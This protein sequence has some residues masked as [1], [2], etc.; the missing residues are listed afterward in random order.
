MLTSLSAPPV[1]LPFSSGGVADMDQIEPSVVFVLICA[2]LVFM[3]IQGVALFYSGLVPYNNSLTQN[4]YSMCVLAL[5]NVQF[6]FVGWSLIHRPNENKIFG[7]LVG[8]LG[9]MLFLDMPDGSDVRALVLYLSK[10]LLT[11]SFSAVSASV[12]IGGLAGRGKFVPSLLFVPVWLTFVYDPIAYW[13]WNPHGWSYR[14]G[15]ID[16]A[17]GTA[18]HCTAGVTALVYAWFLGPRSEEARQHLSSSYSVVVFGTFLLWVGWFG[19]NCGSA[20]EPSVR[21]VN[22]LL[23]TQISGSVG[24]LTWMLLDYSFDGTWS[25]IGFCSGVVAG[26]VCVT[27]GAAMV[28]CWSSVI[29]GICGSLACNFGTKIKFQLGVDDALDVFAAHGIGGFTGSILTG[30]FAQGGMWGGNPGAIKGNWIQLVYQ[31]ISASAIVAYTSG[32]SMLILT[33]F[34]MLGIN[35]RITAEEEFVGNDIS[36]HGEVGRADADLIRWETSNSAQAVR[37]DTYYNR[38]KQTN[39]NVSMIPDVDDNPLLNRQWMNYGGL[40]RR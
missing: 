12:M 30:I 11:L 27:P 7:S 28:S 13:C 8:S 40:D 20:L 31:L 26:L 9:S 21:A 25:I 35:L 29:F 23:N 19:F 14:M 1:F 37:N 17:G 24:G 6:L 10:A 32:M 16:Y 39:V 34:K 4:V 5:C 22:A 36:E 38:Y 3:L 2:G 18:I 33:V 15:A